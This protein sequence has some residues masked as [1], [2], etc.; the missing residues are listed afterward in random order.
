MFSADEE[1][2]GAVNQLLFLW[3]LF[4]LCVWLCM[5]EITLDNAKQIVHN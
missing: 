3:E 2:V 5:C 4:S 1:A